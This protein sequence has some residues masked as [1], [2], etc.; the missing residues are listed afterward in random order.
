MQHTRRDGIIWIALSVFGYSCLPVFTKNL[1]ARGV[2]PLD[3]AVWRY[4]FTVPVFWLIVFARGKR[5]AAAKPLP[6]LRVMLMGMLLGF[7]ALAAFFG[8]Q[9]LPSGTFSVLFYAYPAMVAL[10]EALM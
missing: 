10:L 7:A 2:A 5:P 8:L 1:Y 3:I 6:R 4:L 9:D